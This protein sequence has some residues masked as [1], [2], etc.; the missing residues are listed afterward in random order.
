MPKIILRLFQKYVSTWDFALPVIHE[1]SV[2]ALFRGVD[3]KAL[4]GR[5]T[6][7][8]PIGWVER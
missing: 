7:L 6:D 8:P 4:A 2:R 1:V 3:T 5:H